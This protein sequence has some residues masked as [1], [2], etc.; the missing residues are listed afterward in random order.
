[1]AQR[2]KFIGAPSRNEFW[3]PQEGGA[4]PCKTKNGQSVNNKLHS[5][6]FNPLRAGVTF[7]YRPK[8]NQKRDY[9]FKPYDFL[10]LTPK[11]LP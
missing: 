5:A 9:V 11:V 4:K 10:K 1:M 6:F 2:S 8:S 3:E 7:C